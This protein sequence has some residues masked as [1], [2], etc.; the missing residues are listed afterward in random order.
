MRTLLTHN[1]GE[2]TELTTFFLASP[3]VAVLGF[4]LAEERFIGV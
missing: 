1:I 4:R 3:Q 2:S